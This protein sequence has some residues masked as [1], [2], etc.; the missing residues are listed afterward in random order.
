MALYRLLFAGAV[1]LVL[2]G[3]SAKAWDWGF[4]DDDEE[5]IAEEIIFDEELNEDLLDVDVEEIV[6]V[7]VD[8]EGN[9]LYREV[10]RAGSEDDAGQPRRLG[11]E[12][13]G[14]MVDEEAAP[15]L[16]RRGPSMKDTRRSSLASTDGP[17]RDTI[18]R[19]DYK[20]TT[21]TPMGMR[22]LEAHSA[23]LQDNPDLIVTIEGHTDSVASREYNKRLGLQRARMVADT[24]ERMGVSPSQMVTVSYGEER[25]MQQGSSERAN[26][27]NRRVELVY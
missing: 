7:Y 23:Y 9:E 8:E 4:G 26:E 15:S 3:C 17:P 10:V 2:T 21:I 18:V 6:Y 19:F 22:L 12:N 11:Y 20:K 16:R 13:G 5:D 14:K 24:L 25:P 1:A 27:M